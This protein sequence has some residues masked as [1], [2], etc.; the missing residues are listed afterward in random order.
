MI[1]NKI[2]TNFRERNIIFALIVILFLTI[3]LGFLTYNEVQ[4]ERCYLWE[5]A[6]SEGLNI[7][8]SIQAVG[9][10]LVLNENLLKEILMLLK[11]EGVNYIDICNGNGKILVSTEEERWNNY[12]NIQNPGKINY[13][14]VQ[15]EKGDR[16]L[17]VIK[18]F[19]LM[20][21]DDQSYI[22][23]ILPIKNSYL[24][25]ESI[26]KNI[27]NVLAKPEKEFY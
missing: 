11:K 2:F 6:Q 17:Q 25:I 1:N 15:D 27:I 14:D 26:W 8:F 19:K 23:K 20:N 16:I 13:I 10:R 3:L 5:L 7:A 4:R 12:I 21:M 22:W 24:V 18:P 9:P